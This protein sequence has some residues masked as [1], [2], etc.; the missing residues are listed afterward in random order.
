MKVRYLGHS[1]VEIIGRHHILIDP[2]FTRDPEPGVEFICITH[3]HDDHIGRVAE[4]STGLVVAAPDVCEIAAEMG[5]SRDRLRPLSAGDS[6]A[7][8]HTLPGFS[9]VGGFVYNFFY[10]L[11]TRSLPE[12]GGTPL[13]FLIED[14]V[15]LLHIGDAH[16]AVL[17]VQPDIL[18]LPWRKTPFRAQRYQETLIEMARQFAPS[19]VLPVHHD[20]PPTDAD[21]Q[22]L[23]GRL[24]AKI[25]TGEDWFTFHNHKMVSE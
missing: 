9:K 2:D 11:F 18:C 16:D 5:V 25:L 10:L 13:S 21:P 8:I 23:N 24:S 22:A 20:M 17:D 14:E 19:Y 4:V 15:T 7:N 12:P 6:I 1:C 3:A